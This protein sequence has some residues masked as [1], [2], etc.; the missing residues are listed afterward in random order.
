ML[1]TIE[2]DRKTITIYRV[3]R[4]YREMDPIRSAHKIN[5][6]WTLKVGR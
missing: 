2:S 3:Y 5:I 6:K 1:N 4:V